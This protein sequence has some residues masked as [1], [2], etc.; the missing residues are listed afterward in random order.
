MEFRRRKK[1]QVN[2]TIAPLV[3]I[4][5]LLL[6]FFLL[7]S[8]FAKPSIKL[9]LPSAENQQR[10]RRERI[11]ITVDAQKRIYVNLNQVTLRTLGDHL[12][13]LMAE[14]G[15][16]TVIFRGDRVIPYEIFVQVMDV[17]K[18]AG[19]EHINISHNYTDLRRK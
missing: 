13:T 16:R 17:A 7:A 5:F 18:R 11:I 12:R 6:I 15:S 2:L 14:T 9:T 10:T 3:D 4:V 19:A 1:S 8:S